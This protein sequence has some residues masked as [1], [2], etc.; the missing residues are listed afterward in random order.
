MKGKVSRRD[1]KVYLELD[2]HEWSHLKSIVMFARKT[3]N[4][5]LFPN[6]VE[7]PRIEQMARTLLD[8]LG[9]EKE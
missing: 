1:G 5:P 3:A 7:S 9:F 2:A 6:D 4:G 8:E